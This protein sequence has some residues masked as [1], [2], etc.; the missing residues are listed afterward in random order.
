M[1][2]PPTPEPPL[3]TRE[4]FEHHLTCDHENKH[5]DDLHAANDRH[6]LESLLHNETGENDGDKRVGPDDVP[7][8]EE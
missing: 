7:E 3:Q 2:R 8:E 6:D 5:E 4:E 1:L